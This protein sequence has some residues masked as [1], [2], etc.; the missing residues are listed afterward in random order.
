MYENK[1]WS[2]YYEEGDIESGP[3]TYDTVVRNGFIRKVFGILSIQL[4]LTVLI[5]LPIVLIPSVETF[6][7]ANRWIVILALGLTFGF[8]MAMVCIPDAMR[9]YPLNYILLFSFTICE[10]VLVGVISASYAKDIVMI[11]AGLTVGITIG[12]TFFAMQT[13][14]DFTMMGGIL[15]SILVTLVIGSF[16]MIFFRPN[17]TVNIVYGAIGALLFC[18]Y[19]VYDVQLIA[20]GRRYELGVDDYIPAALAV[21]LDIINIFLFLLRILG[22]SR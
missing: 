10:G 19:L 12:L 17:K 5:A 21:Y 6:L 14:W 3:T 18:A 11:A 22:N 2:R 13:K 20:G 15:V 1:S 8:M 9:K 16:I 4:A 7:L